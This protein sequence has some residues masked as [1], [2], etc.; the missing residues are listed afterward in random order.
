MVFERPEQLPAAHASI[1]SFF[2]QSW[3]NKELL[4]FNSTQHSLRRW[5]QRR[6]YRELRLRHRLPGQMLELCLENCSGEWCAGWQP[7]CWY[8][9]DYLQLHMKHRAKERLVLFKHMRIYALQSRRLMVTNSRDACW[10]L[11]RHFPFN[12]QLPMVEQFEQTARIDNPAHL[13]VKFVREIV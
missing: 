12:P 9:P 4:V 5:W 3:P 7:D 2:S 8:H 1:D 10:S 13:I 11:Y 6:R